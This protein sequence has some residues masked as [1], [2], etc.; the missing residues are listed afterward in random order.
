MLSGASTRSGS[1]SYQKEDNLARRDSTTDAQQ[2]M[3][4]ACDFI[5]DNLY[6]LGEAAVG[7]PIYNAIRAKEEQERRD[8]ADAG[9]MRRRM[10]R[11][12]CE[13]NRRKLFTAFPATHIRPETK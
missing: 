4:A 8:A 12:R 2:A 5:A 10:C 9:A 1:T 3:A 7:S 11:E 13:Q 6:A